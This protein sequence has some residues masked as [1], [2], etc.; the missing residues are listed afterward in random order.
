[1][2]FKKPKNLNCLL[3]VQIYLEL[4]LVEF[5]ISSLNIQREILV[6]SVIQLA[7]LL[8][9]NFQMLDFLIYLFCDFAD[10]FVS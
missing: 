1:M 5:S 6:N 10:S 2:T 9:V 4:F 3:F 8:Q 7:C